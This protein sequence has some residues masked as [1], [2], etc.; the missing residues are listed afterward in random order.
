MNLKTRGTYQAILRALIVLPVPSQLQLHLKAPLLNLYP[1]LHP[2]PA[3][4]RSI[5]SFV[6]VHEHEAEK[7]KEHKKEECLLLGQ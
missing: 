4:G 6:Q 1:H 5:R 7:D 3:Q 2:A